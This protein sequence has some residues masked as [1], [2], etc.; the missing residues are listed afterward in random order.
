MTQQAIDVAVI[1]VEFGTEPAKAIGRAR[2][3]SGKPYSELLKEL[4]SRAL[5]YGNYDLGYKAVHERLTALA[6]REK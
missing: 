3:A 1:N 2:A 6:A 5:F 4:E